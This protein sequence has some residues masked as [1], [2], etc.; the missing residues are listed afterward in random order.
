VVNMKCTVFWVVTLCSLETVLFYAD[1][2]AVATSYI[3][4]IP[5]K[6]AYYQ[7]RLGTG[8]KI[9][10]SIIQ[11]MSGCSMA[12][13]KESAVHTSEFCGNKH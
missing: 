12:Q 8:K 7:H 4:L 6:T 9:Y 13:F 2:F 11:L 1:V 10:T 5:M 3:R